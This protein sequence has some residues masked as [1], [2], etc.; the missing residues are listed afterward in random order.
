MLNPAGIT[1]NLPSPAH[2]N[3][4]P[5]KFL[6]G[7]IYQNKKLSTA[8]HPHHPRKPM[9]P[10]QVIE[11]AA[12]EKFKDSSR[13]VPTGNVISRQVIG[14]SIVPVVTEYR[15]AEFYDKKKGRTVRSPLR[16]G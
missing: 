13:Y 12:E 4:S 8:G 1:W 5:P 11:I 16:S 10:D 6:A 3:G 15:T 14:I 2:L 7:N 9:K